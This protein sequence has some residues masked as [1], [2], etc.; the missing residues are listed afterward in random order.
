MKAKKTIGFS[1]FDVDDLEKIKEYAKKEG[2]TP[3]QL[4]KSLLY[5]EV[6]K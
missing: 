6:F 2:Q 3:S 1:L 4:A 5:K